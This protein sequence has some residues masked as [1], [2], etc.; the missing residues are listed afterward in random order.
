MASLLMG[1]SLNMNMF[2]TAMASEKDRDD[3]RYQ[4]DDDYNR[5]QQSNYEQDRY[6]SS[7]DNS[8]DNEKM[9]SNNYDKDSYD[10]QRYDN[11]YDKTSYSIDDSYS[12]YPTKDKK[13]EC[14]TGQFKGFFVS[15]VE[16]CKLKIPQGPQG[17]QGPAGPAGAAGAAGPKGETGNPGPIGPN[18]TRGPEGPRGEQG[19]QG[20]PG[21]SG[22]SNDTQIICEE[23]IKYWLHF[24]NG[25][26]GGQVQTVV[27]QLIDAI[28]TV[29]FGTD[30]C[31]ETSIPDNPLENVI[32]LDRNDPN[33]EIDEQS[34]LFEICEQLELA[35]LFL[36]DTDTSPEEALALIEILA[37][38]DT[39]NEVA[40]ADLRAIFDCFEE[41]LLPAL[42]PNPPTLTTD[43]IQSTLS[44]SGLQSLS[45]PF[46]D[47]Q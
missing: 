35:L 5:Y 3:K 44:F 18:G 30:E 43:G 37:I 12:K 9:Y 17:P 14:K 22:V 19:P 34:Q 45:N 20:P 4:Y 28:N 32:C 29:N 6:S 27:N 13:Y 38:P 33:E 21:P 24:V 36:V 23:C 42:F 25:G 16:F 39:L 11:S 8:Y 7:Y 46:S 41:D 31:D 47:I 2:S 15:S 10:Q 40:S 1:T 26:N